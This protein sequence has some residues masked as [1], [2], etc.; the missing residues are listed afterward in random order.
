MGTGRN[1]VARALGAAAL[2]VVPLAACGGPDTAGPARGVTVDGLQSRGTA[3]YQGEYLGRTV[4]VSAAVAEVTD[5]GAFE[6]SGGDPRDR[7]LTVLTR[8]PVD[9]RPGEVVQ[10]TGTVGQAHTVAPADPVPYVQR[11]LYAPYETEPFLF[12]ATVEPLPGS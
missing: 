11:P 3:F 1:R 2:L 8:E 6:L 9:V 12:D 7:T 4:T 10:V 5:R